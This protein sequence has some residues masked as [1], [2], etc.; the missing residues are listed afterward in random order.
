MLR[1]VGLDPGRSRSTSKAIASKALPS[2]CRLSQP[3]HRIRGRERTLAYS[4]DTGTGG[5][6]AM[7]R[8]LSGPIA[9]PTR[10]LRPASPRFPKAPTTGHPERRRPHVAQCAR[11]NCPPLP[12]TERTDVRATRAALPRSVLAHDDLRLPL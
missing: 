8:A 9:R 1:L 2:A 10:R 11:R 7:T 12:E 5:W 4:G 3:R 6:A